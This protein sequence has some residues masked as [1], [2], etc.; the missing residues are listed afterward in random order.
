[1][2]GDITSRRVRA[3]FHMPLPDAVSGDKKALG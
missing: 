3:R 2:V 1:M